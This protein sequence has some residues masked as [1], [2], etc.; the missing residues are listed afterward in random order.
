MTF[1]DILGHRAIVLRLAR[2]VGRETLP[3][4]LVFGGAE[5]I[6][7]RTTALALAQALNCETPARWELEDAAERAAVAGP[8]VDACG[9]C[10]TCR[11][12]ADGRFSEVIQLSPDEGG[13]IR[14][15][16]VREV[17]DRVGYRPFEGRR[18]VILIDNADTLQPGAQ[19]AMLKSLEEPG[20]SSVFVLISSRPDAL[21]ATVRSRCPR[22]RFGP[23]PAGL[24][25]SAL[26]ERFGWTDEQARLAAAGAE[27]SLG[28]ALA[29]STDSVEATRD[30][31]V[32]LLRAVAR[33][34]EAP[35]RLEAGQRLA[36][37][38]EGPRRRGTA[39]AS[40]RAT[41]AD[42]L[43]ALA[44]VLRDVSVLTTRADARWLAGAG[45]RSD[46]VDLAAA[47]DGPR[48]VRAFSAVDRARQALERNVSPKV[49]ADW[50]A[51]QL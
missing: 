51:F 23:L 32:D 5:G 16:T 17:L 46:L 49:V 9:R 22:F 26:V 19:N 15:E 40:D 4:S 36:E 24:V 45:R 14:I 48:L 38:G 35:Q 29:A 41:V 39:A 31:A 44:V 21:L 11:R 3:A 47:Y 43:A 18:R 1:R 37:R 8:L 34:A 2:A 10:A 50:L 12:I 30:L 27:G 25:Q 6:G 28:A 20:S 13:S 33:R 42:R 7:K